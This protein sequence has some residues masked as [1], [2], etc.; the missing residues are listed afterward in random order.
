MEIFLTEFVSLKNSQLSGNEFV[1]EFTGGRYFP[2]RDDLLSYV[3]LKKFFYNLE[4]NYQ[5]NN[6]NSTITIKNIYQLSKNKFKVIFDEDTEF[7]YIDTPN[8]LI[9][10][11]NSYSTILLAENNNYI[12][13][14]LY[15]EAEL[16]SFAKEKMPIVSKII[17]RHALYKRYI[18]NQSI[19]YKNLSRLY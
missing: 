14:E 18:S 12:I 8:L 15:N 3:Y 9:N 17:S 1:K 2:V 6:I 13:D 11:D 16:D 5:K 7:N 4:N 19:K 10:E